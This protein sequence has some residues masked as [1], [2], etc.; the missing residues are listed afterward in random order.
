MNVCL[1]ELCSLNV[2]WLDLC[3]LNVCRLD[4]CSLNVFP[5]DLCSLNDVRLDCD[6]E[7]EDVSEKGVEDDEDDDGEGEGG[8]RPLH[9]NTKK[10]FFFSQTL[11][12]C[13]N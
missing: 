12:C 8:H 6:D 13:G 9:T 1:I 5:L 4:L 10:I 3:S 7:A 2:C 11:R